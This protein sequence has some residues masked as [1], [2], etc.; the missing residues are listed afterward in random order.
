MILQSREKKCGAHNITTC[1]L[2]DLII[3]D[4]LFISIIRASKYGTKCILRFHFKPIECTL[5]WEQTRMNEKTSNNNSNNNSA[6]KQPTES[7]QLT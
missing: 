2:K 1:I 7:K 4:F 5:E 3:I 6:E